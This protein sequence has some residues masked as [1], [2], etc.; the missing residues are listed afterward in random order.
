MMRDSVVSKT[1]LGT[2]LD[3]VNQLRLSDDDQPKESFLLPETGSWPETK[4]LMELRSAEAILAA[5][6]SGRP[7]LVRG[8]PGVGK[9]Q[10]AR[11]AAHLLNRR[12]IAAVIQPNTEYEELLWLFDHT[13]RLADAQVAGAAKDSSKLKELTE[14]IAPGPVWFALNWKTAKAKSCKSNYQPPA[15]DGQPDPEKSGVVL[16]IDEIDKADIS[17]ANGLLEVLGNGGFE[18]RSTQESVTAA[19]S[20]PKPLVVLTSNDTREL[21]P[22]LVRRCVVLKMTLPEER[23]DLLKHLVGVGRTHQPDMHHSVLRDAAEQIA[24]D[25]QSSHVMPRTGQ[26]E[27]LDLLRALAKIS[28]D[29][30]EQLKWLDTLG[31]YFH[32]QSSGSL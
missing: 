20:A 16:L 17:V 29:K 32:K 19:E 28:Q 11:A 18:V 12:F 6:A 13:Q 27:Y 3:T 30:N 7:L 24:N 15:G 14:Y 26:A 2:L 22:A 5:L 1:Q 23:E 9:S 31:Q 10:L 8:E 4:H 21:P 25:R